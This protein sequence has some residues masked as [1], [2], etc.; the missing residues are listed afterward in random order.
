M[1]ALGV[2]ISSV[3]KDSPAA[4]A[5]V[6]A[7]HTLLCING[8]DISDV[9]DYRFHM[10]EQKLALNLWDDEGNA[11]A[12]TVHKGEYEE[13]GLDFDT[14]LMDREKSCKNK[15][16]FCFIDQLPPGMRESLYFKDDDSRM[17]FLFGNYIT[18]TNLEDRDIERIIRM[19]ISPVNISVHTTNPEL[20]V[21][22]MKNPRA[23]EVL[24]YLEQLCHAGIKVNGQLVLCPGI[25]DG[26]ELIRSLADLSGYGE[27]L[28]SVSCVPVGLTKFRDGLPAQR[29]FTKE[30]AA[31]VLDTIAEFGDR[32]ETRY[33]SRVFYASD[34]LYLTAERPL[35]DYEYY[36][37]FYQIENGVGMLTSLRHEFAQALA[38]EPNSTSSRKVTLATGEAAYPTIA[39]LAQ[40]AEKRF[41][42][43]VVDVVPI[44]NDFFGPT[45]TVAG[46][47]CGGDI[48]RQLQSRSLG[49]QMLFPLSMLRHDGDLFLDGV[50]VDELSHALGR[51]VRPV[52]NDG[53]DLLEAMLYG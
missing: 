20:R 27:H 35:P 44:C 8:N 5:G 23:G 43:L 7:G 41:P 30:E 31:N 18:L 53:F 25:N 40:A 49:E 4:E 34:E 14:Y 9:L 22:M 17:S 19:R 6:R 33:G 10:M 39:Q 12:V 36:E 15:C 29:L 46:L 32:M 48:I 52:E 21:Q 47:V 38:L 28:Q 13:L 3:D 45:I 26:P 37:D 51:P 16:C 2:I 11:Y 50:S 24:R 1:Q 42:G